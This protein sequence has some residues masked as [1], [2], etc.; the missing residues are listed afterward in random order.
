MLNLNVLQATPLPLY[1]DGHVTL[2]LEWSPHLIWLF[3]YQTK[4]MVKLN[5]LSIRNLRLYTTNF[6]CKCSYSAVCSQI[7]S[8]V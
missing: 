2:V 7:V 6:T 4:G 1:I 5:V 8:H 3:R